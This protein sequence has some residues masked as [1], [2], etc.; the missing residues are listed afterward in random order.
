[1]RV[2]ETK[3]ESINSNDRQQRECVYIY[4]KCGKSCV[5][6]FLTNL[7]FVRIHYSE[8]T[9]ICFTLKYNFF[10]TRPHPQVI[11]PAIS[12][13]KAEYLIQTLMLC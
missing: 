2:S 9:F 6:I 8:I 5:I 11:I 13:I 7:T 10:L 1:M 4:F 3:A 12:F